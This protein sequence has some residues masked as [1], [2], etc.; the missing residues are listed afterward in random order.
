MTKLESIEKLREHAQKIRNDW[1]CFDGRSEKHELDAIADEIQAEIDSHFME[2]PVDADGVLIR[3]GDKVANKNTRYDDIYTVVGLT[4]D[5]IL[6]YGGNASIKSSQV[7][8]V[9][10]RTV[11]D[12]LREFHE[13]QAWEQSPDSYEE[14]MD[15]LTTIYAIELQMRDNKTN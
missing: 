10:P 2:L 15:R 3:V 5:R 11:K 6:V 7:R 12:V 13:D 9:K 14:I 8:H 1:S 4:S